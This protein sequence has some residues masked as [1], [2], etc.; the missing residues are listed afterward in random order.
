M[1]LL[2]GGGCVGIVRPTKWP[3]QDV[4]ALSETRTHRKATFVANRWG[5]VEE[6]ARNRIEE[7]ERLNP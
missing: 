5:A 3:V 7:K 1:N 4:L 2:T 6:L